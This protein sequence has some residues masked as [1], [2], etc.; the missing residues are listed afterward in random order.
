[1]ERCDTVQHRE[2][3]VSHQLDILRQFI[4]VEQIAVIPHV[5][6]SLEQPLAETDVG[7]THV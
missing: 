7:S 1:M 4:V 3:G 2:T 5:I 6:A